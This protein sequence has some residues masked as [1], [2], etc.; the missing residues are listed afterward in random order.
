[1]LND[2]S[3]S[4]FRFRIQSELHHL[5]PKNYRPP[6]PMG[7]KGGCS[8]QNNRE[9]FEP[10]KRASSR[11]QQ[12]YTKKFS[13][14]FHHC[15]DATNTRNQSSKRNQQISQNRRRGDGEKRRRDGVARAC[16]AVSSFI[17]ATW[18]TNRPRAALPVRCWS[19]I[20]TCSIQISAAPSFS[21]PSMTRTKVP[22]A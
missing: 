16:A 18:M 1:M 20:P 19:L 9:N 22:W 7:V 10:T 17:C 8:P 3:N 12:L 11:W 14:L 4:I 2:E 5:W 21:F 6:H 15:H 13:P